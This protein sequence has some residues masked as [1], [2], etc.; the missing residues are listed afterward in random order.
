MEER[1]KVMDI[2]SALALERFKAAKRRYPGAHKFSFRNTGKGWSVTPLNGPRKA[3]TWR[4]EQLRLEQQMLTQQL[5]AS[6]YR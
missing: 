2:G 1:E 3:R 4:E 5:E 6:R